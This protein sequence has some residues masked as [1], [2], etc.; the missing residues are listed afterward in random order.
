MKVREYSGVKEPRLSNFWNAWSAST[1]ERWEVDAG[2]EAK[3]IDKM[4][5]DQLVEYVM[6]VTKY[7]LTE[8]SVPLANMMYQFVDLVDKNFQDGR[9]ADV[10]FRTT[11]NSIF[12]KLQSRLNDVNFIDTERINKTDDIKN[13]EAVLAE[14]ISAFDYTA[15]DLVHQRMVRKAKQAETIKQRIENRRLSRN[16]SGF[17]H[18]FQNW[19]FF[20][21]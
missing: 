1:A 6:D 4:T 14:N 18:R 16:L 9:R 2:N 8:G 19:V 15:L 7:S 20:I 13:I 11:M 5:R 10:V 12:E 17:V 3:K 21:R